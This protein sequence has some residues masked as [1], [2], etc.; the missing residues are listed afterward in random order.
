[1][2]LLLS[3]SERSLPWAQPVCDV[4]AAAAVR[5]TGTKTSP[6]LAWQCRICARVLGVECCAGC[7]SACCVWGR[8]SARCLG[9]EQHCFGH[10]WAGREVRPC[11]IPVVG[12]A[13]LPGVSSSCCFRFGTGTV[14]NIL[15]FQQGRALGCSQTSCFGD[16]KPR[17]EEVTIPSLSS[18]SC[19]Q[20]L[21][22]VISSLLP[23]LHD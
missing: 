14:P 8:A 15:L 21:L 5:K 12:A 23:S 9:S 10:L 2:Q 1:M 20:H 6:R 4:H 7:S 13:F 11:S 3:S 19:H 18:A 17:G 16:R 22:E